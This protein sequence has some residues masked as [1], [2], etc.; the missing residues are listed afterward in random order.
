MYIC[1]LHLYINI[2]KKKKQFHS[3]MSRDKT[4]YQTGIINITSNMQ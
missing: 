4:A 2:D 1:I 3:L